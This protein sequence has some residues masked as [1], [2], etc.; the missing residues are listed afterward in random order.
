MDKT[1]DSGS[2][3]AGS[4][5][6]GCTL[7]K[8]M[9]ERGL[10]IIMPAPFVF[11]VFIL[12]RVQRGKSTRIAGRLESRAIKIYAVCVGT[13]IF[14]TCL[15]MK[16]IG[17]MIMMQKKKLQKAAA[18]FLSL[19]LVGGLAACSGFPGKSQSSSD[20]S[21][22]ASGDQQAVVSSDAS[23]DSSVAYQVNAVEG[24]NTLMTNYYNAYA[25]GDISTLASLAT[26]I[27]Q[28]EQQ[29]ISLVS[30]LV[31]HYDNIT[32]YSK[33]G[34][35]S[36]SYIISVSMDMY[37]TGIST[38][39]PGIETFYVRTSDD[40]NYY[41]DNLYSWFNL[42]SQENPTD[43]SVLAFL[44]DYENSAD[45]QAVFA[46]VQT[47]YNEA[48]NSDSALNT[49]M[50]STLP[51]AVNNWSQSGQVPDLSSDTSSSSTDASTDESSTDQGAQT[52]TSSQDTS[53]D[54]SS[55]DISSTDSSTDSSSESTYTTDYVPEGTQVYLE[56]A[57]NAR[58]SM[59]DTANA[60][61]LYPG[62]TVTVVQSY[63][64]GWTKVTWDGGSG[65]IK[66]DLLK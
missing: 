45:M 27:S 6:V 15:V 62:T 32:V 9:D 41:I 33:P 8:E 55:T 12:K 40:G 39:A 5:P 57:I 14:T 1:P 3:A 47:S 24:I 26:P 13:A 25:N 37:F 48:L 61:L 35:E 16:C 22:S 31:D 65:Y 52:D 30:Q 4:I 59:S 23:A 11:P 28:K 34:M 17:G 53:T 10:H 7:S 64:E 50:T 51:D 44:Q 2:G 43:S 58:A 20:A 19:C 46:E 66:T 36:G 42:S 49:M 21:G 18:V 60:T 38:P 56:S 54:A 63:Q 29:Y